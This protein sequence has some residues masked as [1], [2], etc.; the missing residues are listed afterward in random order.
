MGQGSYQ[1]LGPEVY[2]RSLS[3]ADKESHGGGGCWILPLAVLFLWLSPWDIV[4]PH[5]QSDDDPGIFDP[6]VYVGGP[7][8]APP[9]SAYVIA[10]GHSS[11]GGRLI[12]GVQHRE[13][14][15]EYEEDLDEVLTSMEDALREIK[16][17]TRNT[18]R[19]LDELRRQLPATSAP[20]GNGSPYPHQPMESLCLW[21][22]GDGYIDEADIIRVE[23]DGIAQTGGTWRV[24]IC[25]RCANR[26]AAP[27]PG[28][29]SR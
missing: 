5:W 26:H 11:I 22:G 6:I 12:A 27:L 14:M 3:D 10:V 15:K 29:S 18:E 16:E 1:P 13:R 7:P 8:L 24:G 28:T 17:V 21:C 4:W 25:P 2:E 20:L 23:R 19:D 9:G